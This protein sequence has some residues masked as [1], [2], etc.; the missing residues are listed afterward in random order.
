MRG[1]M[2]RSREMAKQENMIATSSSPAHAIS[3]R[4]HSAGEKP[5]PSLYH[6][7]RPPENN[8]PIARITPREVKCGDI[9]T[10][11]RRVPVLLLH[12]DERINRLVESTFEWLGL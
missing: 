7:Q 4:R 12:G 5:S 6:F 10:L 9:S 8:T 3:E 11:F 1:Y 2:K